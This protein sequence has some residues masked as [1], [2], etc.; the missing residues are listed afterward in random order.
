MTKDTGKQRVAI[1]AR[2]STTGHGQDVG[3]QVDSIRAAA[4][5]RGYTVVRDYVDDGVSGT[6]GLGARPALD[7]LMDDARKGL[8]SILMVNSLCRLGRS[9]KTVLVVLDDLT[10]L[11]IQFVSLTD[12]GM[13][14]TSPQ[15]KL[16]IQII[17]SFAEFQV[18]MLRSSVRAGV[19][20]AKA[21]G[22]HCGRPRHE[23]DIR[24]ALALMEQGHSLTQTAKML[25]KPKST[26]RRRLQEHQEA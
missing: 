13:D 4:E 10:C 20:R 1:Y 8:F 19:A 7:E 12:T 24:P 14:T 17:G 2:V 16:L 5:T 22:K 9:L 26:L 11:G 6:L 18:S 21:Q 3:L 23:F 25:G 15:G